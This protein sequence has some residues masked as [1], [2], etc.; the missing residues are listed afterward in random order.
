[1][2][3]NELLTMQVLYKRSLPGGRK[4]EIDLALSELEANV[5]VP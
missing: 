4:P 2:G 1:M 3:R 5:T